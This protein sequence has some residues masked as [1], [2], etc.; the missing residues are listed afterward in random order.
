MQSILRAFPVVEGDKK[1]VARFLPGSQ[2]I[3]SAICPN[4]GASLL[5]RLP[6]R[7]PSPV[8]IEE[9]SVPVSGGSVPQ[10]SA[11][12][13]MAGPAPAA[14]ATAPHPQPPGGPETATSAVLSVFAFGSGSDTAIV[15]QAFSRSKRPQISGPSLSSHRTLPPCQVTVRPRDP[16]RSRD[17]VKVKALQMGDW[18]MVDNLVVTGGGLPS[19]AGARGDTAS[20]GMDVDPRQMSV[21]APVTSMELDQ[22]DNVTLQG[23]I[24]AF[25]VPKAYPSSGQPDIHRVIS[26]EVAMDLLGRVNKYGLGSSE[27]MQIIR[28]INAHLL[29]PYD[30]RYLAKVLFRPVELGVFE[31]KWRQ[32]AIRVAAQNSQ[33][34]PQD[35]RNG[36]GIDQLTGVGDFANPD[37]QT[38]WRH[39]VLA[40]CQK[41]GMSALVK[42]IELVD[43]KQSFVTIVQGSK[44]P[45]LQ[46]VEKLSESLEKQ[47]EDENA[48]ALFLKELAKINSNADCR[49]RIEALP[50]DPSLPDMVQACANV[51]TTGYKMAALATA[52]QSSWKGP[53]GRQQKQVNAQARKSKENKN[54]K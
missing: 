44:E 9:G 39:R 40:Q 32:L 30:I 21:P 12:P 51:G 33:L 26:W 27:V 20:G 36:I 43:P 22:K 6:S 41:T 5:F 11:N 7:E 46:F 4:C 2:R 24:K 10:A 49:K 53:K 35:P 23:G 28:V 29:A 19:F 15:G 8:P 14:A 52:L 47:V 17:Q 1:P 25:P 54:R 45:F 18:D 31:A 13:T 3:L 42:T 38:T 50:G 34:F 37:Y 16:R 48:R